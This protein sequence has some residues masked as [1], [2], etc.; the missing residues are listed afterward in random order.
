MMI[1]MM[2]IMMMIKRMMMITLMIITMMYMIIATGKINPTVIMFITATS[3][4]M[5]A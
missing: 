3:I 1:E 5:M 2:I 4:A